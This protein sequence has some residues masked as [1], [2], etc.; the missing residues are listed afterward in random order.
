M[1]DTPTNG[2]DTIIGTTGNDH[3]GAQDGDDSVQ[4]NAGDDQLRGDA[5]NDTIDGGDGAD[6]I[7][8]GTGND[9]LSGGAGN[10]SITGGDGADT[11]DGGADN[12]LIHGGIGD[13]QIQGGDG[14]DEIRGDG[15]HDTIEGGA[16]SDT[17]HGNDGNDS[18]SGGAGDDT[19]FGGSGA[20]IFVLSEGGGN[21]V[22]EDFN[23]SSGDVVDVTYPGFSSFADIQ[24][25]LSDDGNFGT[26]ISMPDGT[27]MQLKFVN[28]SN[29]D[30]S[31]FTFSA[32][33][34]CFLR[35]TRIL[36]ASGSCPIE[37]IRPGTLVKTVEGVFEPVLMV[38]YQSF[39]FGTGPHRMKP[40]R[41]APGAFG[42]GHPSR[43][44]KMSP[45]HR[46]AMPQAAPD[47]FVPVRKMLDG[48]KISVRSN[49]KR[50]RYYN[51]LLPRHSIINA[52]G[53]WVESLLS[54]PFTRRIGAIPQH[55]H[56]YST[57]AALRIVR[58]LPGEVT[59]RSVVRS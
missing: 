52:E 3:I 42:Q 55:L 58:R 40:I 22:I 35:G 51:L 50:A 57:R 30:A 29:V 56:H 48:Q 44:L 6:T 5:G 41:I 45:Q 38:V 16:G 32:A 17:L 26:L 46:V 19:L 49:C 7:E 18:L 59:C 28:F 1:A 39:R 36:T 31:Y 4:G 21:D 13:D 11:I 12:D 53:V 34:V 37:E 9:S 20:D 15:G 24:P 2:N 14:A 33:P 27:T 23:A 10:D 25:F 47:V 8:G 43:E 54:T